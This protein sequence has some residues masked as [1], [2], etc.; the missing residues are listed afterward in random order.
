MV[1]INETEPIRTILERANLTTKS[2]FIEPGFAAV[3]V[4][5]ASKDLT[6]GQPAFEGT[7]LYFP[8]IHSSLL[9]R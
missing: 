8:G 2:E 4:E 7:L 3:V 6:T 5:V 1:Q 9:L